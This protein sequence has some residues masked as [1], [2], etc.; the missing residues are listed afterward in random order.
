M[1]VIVLVCSLLYNSFILLSYTAPPRPHVGVQHGGGHET[2]TYRAGE[3][4][5]EIGNSAKGPELRSC[6]FPEREI[7][8]HAANGNVRVLPN[9]HVAHGTVL[10]F[11]CRPLGEMRLVGNEWSQCMN[12]TWSNELPYCYGPGR[13]DVVIR[14]KDTAGTAVSPDGYLNIDPRFE[15]EMECGSYYYTPRLEMIQ[16]VSIWKRGGKDIKDEDGHDVSQLAANVY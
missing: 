13:Y 16:P 9:D 8:F 12:G 5:S 14:L 4:P 7:R 1:C 6:K 3:D 10:R 15:A 11:H 2:N